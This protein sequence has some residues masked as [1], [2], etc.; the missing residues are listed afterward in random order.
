MIIHNWKEPTQ[1]TKIES[2]D[3]KNWERTPTKDTVS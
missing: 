1:K 3:D 2:R